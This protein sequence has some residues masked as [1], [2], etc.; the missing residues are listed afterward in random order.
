MNHFETHAA[1]YNG[2]IKLA[3]GH[4]D[5]PLEVAQLFFKTYRLADIR[6]ALHHLLQVALTTENVPFTKASQRNDIAWF[7][8]DLE[9]LLEAVYLLQTGT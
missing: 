8:H 5:Q 7:C 1:F 2:I 4:H 9:E 3:K 6:E